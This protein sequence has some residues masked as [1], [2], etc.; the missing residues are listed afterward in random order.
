[1]R[2]Y[3][4]HIDCLVRILFLSE[5]FREIYAET[6]KKLIIFTAKFLDMSKENLINLRNYLYGTLDA[7]DMLWLA[8]ELKRRLQKKENIKPYTREELYAMIEESERQYAN[9]EYFSTEEVL[10]EIEEEE[11]ELEAV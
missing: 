6:S 3:W 8:D 9:G 4:R 10:S 2:G 11:V 1:M 5:I 7:D